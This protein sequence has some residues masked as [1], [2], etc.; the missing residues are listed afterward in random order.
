MLIPSA[1]GAVLDDVLAPEHDTTAALEDMSP[2][3]QT[4]VLMSEVLVVMPAQAE[5]WLSARHPNRRLVPK[6]VEELATI[7][8]QGGWHLNGEALLFDD[9]GE[10]GR[11]LD[12]QHR[13][14]AVVQL[15][16]P[17]PFLIVRGVSMDAQAT[18]GQALR[19][20][21]ADILSM[22]QQASA[23]TLAGAL[24]VLWRYDH[25]L[26]LD[27]KRTFLAQHTL[28]VLLRYPGLAASMSWG[29]STRK[30]LPG[31]VG[32]ALHYLLNQ[33]DAGLAKQVFGRLHDGLE[34]TASDPLHSLREKLIE[35]R[36]RLPRLPQW[37]YALWC[38]R[39]WNALR[40]G[41][42]PPT[43]PWEPQVD[44]FPHVQ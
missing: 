34:L 28:E 23:K 13:L 25:G 10:G 1:A 41:G 40:N 29:L 8:R 14:A 32:A 3:V 44:R 9:G 7:M 31:S 15:G 2:E 19:R 38:V 37:V 11:L 22:H 20:S 6:H 39:T 30:F 27:P 35:A 18:L 4:P 33:K 12:G 42:G 24:G 16:K 21:K 26:M 5:A 17:V 43:L 36:T